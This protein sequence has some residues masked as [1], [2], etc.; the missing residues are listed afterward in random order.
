MSFLISEVLREQKEMK[1]KGNLYYRTQIMFAYNTN[2][3]EGNKLS[4]NQ[5]KNIFETNT[6]LLNFLQYNL[7]KKS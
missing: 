4:K 2:H 7:S 5:T 1:L 6:I 3:I